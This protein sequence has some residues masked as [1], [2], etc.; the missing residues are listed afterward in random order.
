MSRST[1]P[2]RVGSLSPRRFQCPRK[3]ALMPFRSQFDSGAR[4]GPNVCPSGSSGWLLR[5]SLPGERFQ[6]DPL[7][8]QADRRPF[9]DVRRSDLHQS[10]TSPND[11]DY[12][13]DMPCSLPRWIGTGATSA[14]S[15]SV[16]PSR[17]ADGSASTIYFR[18]LLK[19]HAVTAFPIAHPPEVGFVTRPQSRQLPVQTVRQL[20]SSAVCCPGGSFPHWG[21]APLGRTA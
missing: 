9:D 1:G 10:W 5:D 11:P 18:G 16:R 14:S 2:T 15:V 13:L 20:P 21:S 7:R 6:D 8:R 4:H 17:H 12:P 3:P 19:L